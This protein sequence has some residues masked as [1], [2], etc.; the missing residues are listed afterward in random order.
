MIE[1]RLYKI[2]SNIS[3]IPINS[4]SMNDVD[5]INDYNFDSVKMVQL[6]IDIEMEFDIC[7]EDDELEID[8]LNTIEKLKKIIES[9][10]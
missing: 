6:I 10:I 4:D 1:N 3:E 2:I 7:F 8:K 9:K 5:I